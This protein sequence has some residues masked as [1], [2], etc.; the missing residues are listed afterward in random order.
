MDVRHVV[1]FLNNDDLSGLVSFTLLNGLC[2][3]GFGMKAHFFSYKASR[4]PVAGC[5]LPVAGHPRQLL[6]SPLDHAMEGR[7]STPSWKPKT[8]LQQ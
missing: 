2:F 7:S 4:L 5:R 8:V 6:A 3:F 1:N